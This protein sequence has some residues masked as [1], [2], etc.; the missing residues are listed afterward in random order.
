MTR[1]SRRDII[2]EA[3]AELFAEK[4]FR[5]TTVR[6]IADVAVSPSRSRFGGF[7]CQGG[8]VLGILRRAAPGITGKGAAT[9]W[10]NKRPCGNNGASSLPPLGVS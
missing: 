3:A 10:D 5:A 2:I 1:K 6:D 4:G 8:R 7:T 9:F